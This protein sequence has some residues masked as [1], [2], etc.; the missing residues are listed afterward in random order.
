MGGA[1]TSGTVRRLWQEARAITGR[2]VPGDIATRTAP[3]LSGASGGPKKMKRGFYTIMSAQFFSSLADNALFVAAVELLRVSGTG[4]WQ[5]APW[6]RS[7]WWTR[8]CST[9]A[10]T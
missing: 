1:G 9:G 2:V 5:R 3:A 7:R 8:C 6:C 10:I 4:E